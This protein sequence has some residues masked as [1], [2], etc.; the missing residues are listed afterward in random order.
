MQ[1]ALARRGLTLTAALCAVAAAADTASALPSALVTTTVA[2]AL[3]AAAGA[4]GAVA[5]L[6]NGVTKAMFT[7]KVKTAMTLLLAS[8]PPGHRRGDLGSHGLCRPARP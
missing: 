3:G 5:A 7:S 8:R 6:A 2:A 4:L 1:Q